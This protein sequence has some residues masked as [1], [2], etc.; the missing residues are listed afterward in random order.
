[1]ENEAIN[2][3]L[4]ITNARIRGK[5]RGGAQEFV[6]NGTLDTNSL[7]SHYFAKRIAN[8][9]KYRSAWY[10]SDYNEF[11]FSKFDM[12]MVIDMQNDFV[13]RVVPGLTGPNVGTETEKKQIGAF[14]VTNGENIINP[15]KD[16][17]NKVLDAKGRVVF[18][19]DIHPCDHCSFFKNV[20]VPVTNNE[21]KGPFPPHC[22]NQTVGAGLVKEIHEDLTKQRERIVSKHDDS[23]QGKYAVAFKGC[24]VNVDSFGAVT[25]PDEQYSRDRQ[26]GKCD[27]TKLNLTGCFY[28]KSIEKVL[29][30]DYDIANLGTDFGNGTPFEVPDETAR[31]FVVGLAG[32]YCVRDTALNLISKYPDKEVIVIYE[33][34]RNAF[35]PFSAKSDAELAAVKNP[36]NNKKLN[37]YVFKY[38]KEYRKSLSNE[39]LEALTIET[40]Y[41]GNHFH[42]LT[43]IEE[44]F[45]GYNKHG[46]QVVVNKSTIDDANKLMN[47]VQP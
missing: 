34:T 45:N 24:N 19:R 42:F 13:D 1:M 33:L 12:L 40:L 46:V 38:D 44:I 3:L 6:A 5:N 11:E 28:D 29:E 23:T 10:I 35:I 17:Y 27:K 18:T 7:L 39:E 16:L 43:D 8:S 47:S 15:I 22:I 21:P 20:C 31:V 41:D 26:L 9:G 2:I 14:A 37:N 4:G 30:D 36:T 25:Y 32:D